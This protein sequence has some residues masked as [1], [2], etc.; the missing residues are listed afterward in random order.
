MNPVTRALKQVLGTAMDGVEVLDYRIAEDFENLWKF[1]VSKER[2]LIVWSKT[3]PDASLW[4]IDA[5]ACLSPLEWAAAYAR[6]CFPEN[7]A[8]PEGAHWPQIMILDADPTAHASVPTLA[9]FHTLREDQ[10]PWL[11][12]PKLPSLKDVCKWFAPTTRQV[13]QTTLAALDRFLREIRLNLTEVRTEGDYDR[14]A[15][16]N[17]VAPMVLLGR[18]VTDSRH[19]KALEKLLRAC[20]ICAAAMPLSA[21]ETTQ[22]ASDAAS[23]QS[24]EPAKGNV[25]PVANDTAFAA[26]PDQDGQGNAEKKQERK[27]EGSDLSILLVDDQAHHGWTAWLEHCFPKAVVKATTS[28]VALV[29]S[30]KKQLEDAGSKD[31]RFRFQL[32]DFSESANPVLFL[33][34]RLFSGNPSAEIAFLEDRLL[35][36]IDSYFLEQDDRAWPSFSS[37]DPA[38]RDARDVINNGMLKPESSLHHETLT[39]L[40]RVLALADMSLPVVIFSSTDRASIQKAFAPYGNILTGFQKPSVASIREYAKVSDGWTGNLATVTS[41]IGSL[42]A[43]RKKCLSLRDLGG[44]FPHRSGHGENALHV[45]LYIDEDMKPTDPDFAVGGVF[46]VF[47]SKAQADKFEDVCVQSKL[48]YFQD[49]YFSPNVTDADVLDKHSENGVRQL[50]DSLTAFRAGGNLVDLGYVRLR[51]GSLADPNHPLSSHEQD[52]RFWRMLEALVELFCSESLPAIKRQYGSNTVKFSVFVGSRVV[53]T[54]ETGDFSYQASIPIHHFQSGDKR[55]RSLGERDA[56]PLVLKGLSLHRRLKEFALD[57]AAALALPYKPSA[58]PGARISKKAMDRVVHR[59]SGAI[60]EFDPEWDLEMMQVQVGETVYGRILKKV[61]ANPGNNFTSQSIFVRVCGAPD[62]VIFHRRGCQNFDSF[63]QGDPVRL[64]V[65]Q[66]QR[67]LEGTNVA[68]CTENDLSNWIATRQLGVSTSFLSG[69]DLTDFRPDFRALHYVA[70][71]AMRNAAI[72][73]PLFNNNLAGQFDEVYTTDLEQCL[74][75]SR[76]LDHNQHLAAALR[77]FS[78]EQLKRNGSGLPLARKWTALR[79]WESLG[80]SDSRGEVLILS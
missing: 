58:A 1:Q 41:E 30:L 27:E 46:G 45:E 50:E 66:G 51:R 60:H 39:W 17:I 2:I 4:P 47:R 33:D 64:T 75:A 36:L 80:N 49:S 57:R 21:P 3:S 77:S 24:S 20:G 8:Q 31:L 11:T 18:S 28:P 15:I 23:E 35:P 10:L 55:L 53:E 22:L 68:S 63:N 56:F 72:F 6:H 76:L 79:L 32:P 13:D 59:P 52:L 54:R 74:I 73:L 42:L 29:E 14:H 7:A 34:L 9:H 61:G 62:N 78:V 70:D 48:R 69:R 44:Q 65:N 26:N 19:A 38:F 12:V 67:G 40:P 71:Q 43:I 5:S 25:G 16:S 37:H